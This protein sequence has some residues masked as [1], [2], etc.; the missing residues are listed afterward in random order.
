MLIAGVGL[1]SACATWFL[2]ANFRGVPRQIAM[3]Q[4][5]TNCVA[6]LLLAALL[7][8]EQ[9][10]SAPLL[11]AATHAFRSTVSQRMAFTYLAL[12]LVIA[13]VA[14]AG[15]PWA[16]RML[17][18]LW[19]PTPEQDLS[20]P[21]YI[22]HDSLNSP[23]TALELVALEQLRIMKAMGRSLI[24]LRSEDPRRAALVH[25]AASALG[26]RVAVFLDEMMGLPIGPS[27][28]TRTI[29]F[30]RKQA[31]LR[32]LE[33]NVFLFMQALKGHLHEEL[34]DLLVE[35]LATIL[36]IATSS[37]ESAEPM[38]IDILIGMTDDRSGMMEEMR[39]RFGMHQIENAG[40]LSAIHYATTLFERNVWLLRQ[41]ALWMRED[42]K[43]AAA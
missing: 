4:A 12:N 36:Q 22:Q 15:L 25:E 8:V 43:L 41:L 20:R 10:T 2:S 21:L 6:C 14:I 7:T 24:E 23:E 35:A 5:F 17:G 28:A 33:E 9:V 34:A 16:P 38:E 32:S 13:M 11:M 26:Y 31:S 18:R 37:L 1:G 3:Y 40:S 19:P 42:L 27:L 29:G 30:Q 39:N